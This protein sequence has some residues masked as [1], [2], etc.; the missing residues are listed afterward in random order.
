MSMATTTPAT[1]DRRPTAGLDAERDDGVAELTRTLTIRVL[2]VASEV[3]PL[4]RT[5]GAAGG[6]ADVVG[7]LPAALAHEGVAVRTLVPGYPAVVEALGGAET[8][9]EIPDLFGGPARVLA[10]VAAGLDLLAIDAPHLYDRPGY[11]YLAP[12]GTDW[13]DNAARFGALGLVAARIGTGLIPDYRPDIVHGHDWQ[14]GLAPAYLHFA[15]YPKPRTV[16]TVHGLA[17]AGQFPAPTLAAL[18]LPEDAFR[19]EGVEYHG[20]LSFLKAALFYADRVTAVSPGYAAEIMTHE[21]GMGFDGLLR[22]RAATVTGI[23]NGIDDAVWDPA[24]D[25]DIAAPFG[26][27]DM[28]GRAANKAALQ[29]RFGLDPSPDAP[30]FGVVSRLSGQKG[31]DLVLDAL[32]LLVALGG[33]LALIGEGDRWF[34]DSFRAAA[35]RHPGT[36]GVVIGEDERLA[37]LLQAG[38]DAV[39]VPSRFEPCGVAQL[40]ALRYGA[41]PVVARVGSLADT[42]VDANEMALAAG[43]ATG[44]MFAPA[45]LPALETAL[46]RTVEIFRDPEDWAGMVVAGMATDVS[47]RRPA[48]KL[49]ALYRDLLVSDAGTLP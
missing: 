17:F 38:A 30:L 16:A 12:D 48:R 43:A 33:Q 20:T 22:A 7:A 40:C 44:V 13:P 49:A 41:V 28:A 5:G 8:V 42:V 47:W 11:P 24:N 29:E 36:V 34:E 1:T 10:G 23:R 39:L 31:L 27:G 46:R 19:T 2:S 3:H 18:G 25:P 14:A 26:V 35:E 15:Q 32:P 4:V 6:L 21:S 37:H 45:T 9:A